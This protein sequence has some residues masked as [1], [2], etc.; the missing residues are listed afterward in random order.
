MGVIY[1]LIWGSFLT[2]LL[3]FGIAQT[4][5]FRRKFVKAIQYWTLV[6]VVY[7]SSDVSV[8]PKGMDEFGSCCFIYR[9]VGPKKTKMW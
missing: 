7:F 4:N 2:I 3:V 5:S 9:Y 8:A 6:G 1:H